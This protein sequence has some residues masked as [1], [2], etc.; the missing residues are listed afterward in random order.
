M[1]LKT[2][3]DF[4]KICACGSRKESHNPHYTDDADLKQ[5]AIKRVKIW[6][7]QKLKFKEIGN[8]AGVNCVQQIQN[9]FIDFFNITEE[10]LD[11]KEVKDEK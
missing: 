6:E 7:I 9:E 4:N 10:D 1:K 5:E 3:K 11:A 8:E 2:L